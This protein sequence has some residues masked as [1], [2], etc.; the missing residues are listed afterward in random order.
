MGQTQKSWTPRGLPRDA[1][2]RT[3]PE[4]SPHMEQNPYEDDENRQEK[5]AQANDEHGGGT[6]QAEES[7]ESAGQADD[8][9]PERKAESG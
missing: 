4:G 9:E 6:P 5:F 3:P 8:S 2:E 1:V 7:E